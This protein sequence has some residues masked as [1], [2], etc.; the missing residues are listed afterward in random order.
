[1]D[2]IYTDNNLNELGYLDVRYELDMDIGLSGCSENDFELTIP[3]NFWDSSLQKD[4]I[5]FE[6]VQKSEVGGIIN[7]ISPNTGT[8]NIVLHGITWRGLISNQYISPPQ[9]K[10]YYEARGD[11]N[12]FLCDVLN[13]CFNG[14][15]VGSREISGFNVN[16]DIRYINMLEAI[17]KTLKKAG[18]N[19]CISFDRENHCAVCSAVPRF[20]L[21]KELSN[22]YGY[23]MQAKDIEDGY[24][25]C[26]CLGQGELEE[27]R[28]INLYLL[29][30]GSVTQNE[31]QAISDGNVGIHRKTTVYENTSTDSDEE[32]IKGGTDKLF[33]GTKTL[34]ISNVTDVSI[35]DLV[36]AKEVITG[37]EMKKVIRSKI[38][39]GFIN[40]IE[41]ENKVGD[42]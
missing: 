10:A 40:N 24:N 31:A 15:I 41:V 39:K 1:M 25:H 30:N 38:Y 6:D 14:L 32:L 27:R 16:Y 3:I 4:S 33:H 35:G 7:G 36:S 8:Q 23:D 28:V 12:K 13:D 29:K 2:I 26:I 5:I 42:E 37:I 22:D 9:G 19:L 18:L 21:N 17:E 20:L 34:E 11:A